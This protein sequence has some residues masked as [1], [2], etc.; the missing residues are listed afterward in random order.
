MCK[1]DPSKHV[2]AKAELS[3][4]EILQIVWSAF[5]EQKNRQLTIGLR[6]NKIFLKNSPP[7]K[8]G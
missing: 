2:Y 8:T 7:C 3:C 1:A 4:V 6:K 5:Q